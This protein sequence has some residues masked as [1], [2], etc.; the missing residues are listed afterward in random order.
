M[1]FLR[2]A[3]SFAIGIIVTI[4]LTAGHM[5]ADWALYALGIFIC[6]V[7]IWFSFDV[8]RKEYD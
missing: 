2:L 6:G 8:E 7:L 1:Q 4:A 5:R 3:A